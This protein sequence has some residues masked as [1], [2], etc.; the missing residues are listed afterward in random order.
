MVCVHLAELEAALLASGARETYRG[1]PWSK[2]CREWVY[3]DVQ[4]NLESVAKRF[5]LTPPV[6][7][8]ENLDPRSGTERG[9]VCAA[10]HHAIMGRLEGGRRFG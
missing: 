9:F 2:N 1:R 10:C 4:M 8:H 6:E 7:T 5:A 3:F